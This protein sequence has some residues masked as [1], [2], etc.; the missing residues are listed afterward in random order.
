MRTTKTMISDT[1]SQ[2][3][4]F[5]SSN[6]MG[7][8]VDSDAVLA[9]GKKLVAELELDEP[10]DT[11]SRW[12]AHYVAELMQA[13]EATDAEQRQE[14]KDRCYTAILELWQH[15]SELPGGKRPFR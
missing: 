6:R 3:L 5:S 2:T 13:A 8:S 4:G 12:M 14:I 11:L 7:Q 15:R 10:A 9:L 1:S